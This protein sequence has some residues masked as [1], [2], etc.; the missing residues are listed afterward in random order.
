MGNAEISS[1]YLWQ[2]VQQT[3][4]QALKGQALQPIDTQACTL[5]DG[6]F[7]FVVRVVDNIAR[8]ESAQ[9]K[10]EKRPSDKLFD[11]FL[12]YEEALFVADLSDTHLCLLNKFNVVDHHLLIVTRHYESQDEWLT[13]ADF[14]GLAQCLQEIPGLGFYNGG[15]DAGASQHHKHLQLIPYSVEQTEPPMSAA[16]ERYNHTLKTQTLLPSL[17]FFHSVRLLALS[18]SPDSAAEIAHELFK[19]YQQVMRDLEIDLETAQP[20]IPYNLLVTRDWMM[21]VRRSQGE[22]QTIGVNS[23]GYAGW[24]LVKDHADLEK[25]KE[26]GPMNLLQIV[27]QPI[28]ESFANG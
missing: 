22:Y 23:L 3:T 7:E 24:L 16:I 8:K 26:V 14:E 13:A 20:S 25:L 12:P 9:R 15:K 18:W 19:T 10:R 4:Q 1:S 2:Q 27:G 5:S 21:G 28:P 6:S 11:P 17:P